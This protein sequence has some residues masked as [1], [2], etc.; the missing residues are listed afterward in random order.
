[1]KLVVVLISLCIVLAS[2]GHVE[3]KAEAMH[4]IETVK[5]VWLGTP[6]AVHDKALLESKGIN[7][8]VNVEEWFL[9]EPESHA[10]FLAW[11]RLSADAIEERFNIANPPFLFYGENGISRPA[12]AVAAY[13]ILK[14]EYAVS[15]AIGAI[16]TPWQ[17]P[18]H[19]D[20]RF[21]HALHDLDTT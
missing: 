20:S 16:Q 10:G 18:Q 9:G 6:C 2:A 17:P 14:Y 4:A 7:D 19:F 8:V 5:G 21:L 13:L 15:D 3:C 1:M 11:L 12:A